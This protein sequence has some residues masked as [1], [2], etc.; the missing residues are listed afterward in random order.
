MS[1]TTTK[2]LLPYILA[3]QAQKHVTHNEALR[4]LDG[5]VHLS[6][7]DRDLAAPPASPADGDRY[8]VA[9]GGTGDWAGW[10]LN[11]AVFTDGTWQRLP[12][13]AG[14]RAWVEDEELLLVYDGSAWVGTTPASL[15]NLAL[16]GL[17]TT[18]DAANP[19][20]AKLNAALWTA[21]TVAEGGT[22]DLFYTMNKEAAGDDLGL[23]LQT[24][25][26]T[27]ALVGLFGSDNFRLAV[28]VDGSTFF[29]GL[30]VD[31][32]TGIVDQPQLPRFKAWT[33]YDNYVGVG[34]WTK[35]GLN[36]T[37]TNDQGAFDAGTNLF[38][39]PVNGT[40]LFG[41]TLLYKVNSST[42]ARMRG[43]LVLNG[44][45]EI[46]GSIGEISATHV[47]LATAIWL[48]T[49][50]PLTAGDTVELQGY[51]RVADGYFAADHTS[52]WGCKVG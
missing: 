12:P 15:Q 17:G 20:S 2:L 34:A 38:T 30:I 51:F 46:R 4:I 48:Q 5:L 7:F 50:V 35:I 41:A 36:N 26:V 14:W 33:N 25:F 40:Y 9:S 27:K 37:E 31:N 29:D 28:S 16:L 52:F 1:D 22:G 18:A 45:T 11:V 49:M 24:G 23:T 39:A 44:A 3:A 43:R 13:R 32:A 21:K 42:S 47:T 6:V 8:I 10:D 19:F